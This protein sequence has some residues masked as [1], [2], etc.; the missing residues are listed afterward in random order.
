MRRFGDYLGGWKALDGKYL[1]S[2][3]SWERPGVKVIWKKREQGKDR[4]A[5]GGT[6][7]PSRTSLVPWPFALLHI[8]HVVLVLFFTNGKQHPPPAKRL[9]LA[10]LRC[11]LCYDQSS[12]TEAT[13]SLRCACRVEILF[14]VQCE[15]M[16]GLGQ[17]RDTHRF[18]FRKIKLA[19]EKDCWE[20]S[21]RP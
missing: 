21:R 10:A 19:I 13:I 9:R 4:W 17:E 3:R 8:T 15:A 2:F 12:G 14:W 7:Q 16:E 1:G 6:C 11:S 18:T 20:H 5:V